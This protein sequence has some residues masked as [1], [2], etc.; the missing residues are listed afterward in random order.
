MIGSTHRHRRFILRRHE[1]A[2]GVSG[3]GDVAWGC[4]FSDGGCALRW[5]SSSTSTAVYASIMDVDRIHG[6][7]GMTEIVWIDE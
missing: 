4:Q 1:D 2:S 5:N 3:T 6:H 7:G